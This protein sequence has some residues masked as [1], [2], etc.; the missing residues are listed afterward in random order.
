MRHEGLN[1]EKK[2]FSPWL[3]APP[4]I[5]IQVHMIVPALFLGQIEGEGQSRKGE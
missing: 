3:I 4:C 5:Y 1:I 2:H